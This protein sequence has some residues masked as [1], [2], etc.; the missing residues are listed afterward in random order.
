MAETKRISTSHG[1][2]SYWD[3][4]AGK[5]ETGV[6]VLFVHGNSSVKEMFDRQIAAPF[7]QSRRLIS[8]DLPGHGESSD[9]PDPVAAYAIDGF[10]EAGLEFLRALNIE[11]AVLVGWSLG[12]H[13]VLEMAAQ[14]SGACG[15]VITGTPPIGGNPEDLA[16]AF[17]PSDHMELTFKPAFSEEEARAYA[18]ETVGEDVP[19]EAWMVDAARRADGCF[20]PQLLEAAMSGRGLDQKKIVATLKTSLAVLHAIDDPFISL[21]FLKQLSYANLWRGAVQE[22]PGLAH[23]PFWQDPEKFNDLLGAFLEDV[24]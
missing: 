7:A 9:A 8:L 18:Q 21:D 23:A 13:I 2:I 20:R 15:V 1:E 22:M 16:A 11:K 3:H 4:A 6:P 5:E 17:L 12:G 24:D 19:L 14:W 10:A